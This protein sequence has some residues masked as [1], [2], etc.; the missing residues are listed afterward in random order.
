MASVRISQGRL[1]ALWL[2]LHSA[3]KLGTRPRRDE[4]YGHAARSSLRAGGLPIGDGITLALEGGFLGPDGDRLELTPLG[5]DALALEAADEPSPAVRRLFLSV[6]LLREP[7]PWVAY[8]QGDPGALELVIPESER[9]LLADVGL[10][11]PRDDGELDHWSWWDAMRQVPLPDETGAYRKAIGDAGEELSLVYE[12]ARLTTAGLPELAARVRWVARE[13]AA[14]G[15]DIASFH[16][17]L[18]PSEPQRPLAVEV[19]SIARPAPAL[20]E[21]FLT[22]HEWTTAQRLGDDHLV[23]I[24]DGVDPGPPPRA[25]LREPVRVASA[26]LVGHVPLA[27]SCGGECGWFTA[28][29]AVRASEVAHRG[30]AVRTLAG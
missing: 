15:F 20:L 29:L 24:W 7:P 21:F 6:L 4:V 18:R 8:W 12:R 1:T 22:A 26:S 2:V 17:S 28:R 23:H 14:Y 25:R 13:S 5:R 11:P 3:E 10:Y 9:D 16:G 30:S 27:P 19:K